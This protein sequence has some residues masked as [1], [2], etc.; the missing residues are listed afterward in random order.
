MKMYGILYPETQN[1]CCPQDSYAA[2]TEPSHVNDSGYCS[3]LIYNNRLANHVLKTITNRKEQ[4]IQETTDDLFEDRFSLIRSKLEL[5][6][7]QLEE[8]KKINKKILY[9][10][11]QDGCRVQNLYF[12]LGPKA[13]EPSGEKLTLEKMRFDLERQ[14]RNEQ[15]TYFN[16]T[17]FLNRE[18]RDTL[19][20]YLDEVQK[21]QLFT[22]EDG[23]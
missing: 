8:R 11:D 15:S 20:Q 7:L 1:Y 9:Q 13:Y 21:N 4:T 12:E 10:I 3:H 5:I 18:L 14:R 17:A 19:I 2:L 6:I 22:E 23:L 16:D